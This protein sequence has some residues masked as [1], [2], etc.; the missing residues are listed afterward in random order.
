MTFFKEND[1]IQ[2]G[3]DCWSPPSDAIVLAHDKYQLRIKAFRHFTGRWN[4]DWNRC[5]SSIRGHD[6]QPHPNADEVWASY[7]AWRLTNE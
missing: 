2:Y 6:P 3:F 1:V 7:V 4:G 5:E